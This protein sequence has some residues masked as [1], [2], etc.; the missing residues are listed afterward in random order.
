MPPS[1]RS[2]ST[3]CN[4]EPTSAIAQ[5]RREA[6]CNGARRR[7]TMDLIKTR[8]YFVGLQQR[9]V[10][11][12]EAIDGKAFRR[13]EWARV[14]GGGGVTCAIENGNVLERAGVLFSHVTGSTLPP[15]ATAQR[16][17]LA[18]RT[19]EAMGVSLVLHPRNPY[20]PTVHMNVRCF[21]AP[22]KSAA[23]LDSESIW[24]FGGG[25]DL[26]PYYGYVEDAVHFHAACRDA[27][28]PFGTNLYPK[29]KRWC[30]DYFFL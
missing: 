14:E 30:D 27:L 9:I 10:A 17:E 8:A 25:M 13:D 20:A 11:S 22:E 21:V 19:W 28:A 29:Y 18:G 3:A 24:W 12:L 4:I 23:Q 15:S 26:T 1:R 7:S 2:I 16:P 6:S 5:S